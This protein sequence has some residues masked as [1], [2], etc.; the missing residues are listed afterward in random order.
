MRWVWLGAAT[1]TIAIGIVVVVVRR[2]AKDEARPPSEPD[3]R[4]VPLAGGDTFSQVP[5]DSCLV[6][7]VTELKKHPNWMVRIDQ[8]SNVEG[9]IDAPPS[10][11]AVI[12]LDAKGAR[13]HDG[14]RTEANTELDAAAV[15]GLNRAIAASCAERSGAWHVEG[16]DYVWFEI[17][18]GVGGDASLHLPEDSA[19]STALRPIFDAGRTLHIASETRRARTL[20]M[21]L[22]GQR[23]D[24]KKKLRA[25]ELVI[26]LSK[27]ATTDAEAVTIL[28]WAVAQPTDLEAG[29]MVVSGTLTVEGKSRPVAINLQAREREQMHWAALAPLKPLWELYGANWLP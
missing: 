3:V 26:D 22:K 1:T 14:W 24:A 4:V 28:D 2:G 7:T 27:P 11:D 21:T 29:S 23:Q 6:P 16:T 19:A 20:V 5:T 9:N 8:K 17:G 18:Y 12:E 15:E 10:L 13:W 25:W